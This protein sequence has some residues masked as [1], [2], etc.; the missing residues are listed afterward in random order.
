MSTRVTISQLMALASTRRST[1]KNDLLLGLRRTA[2]L[3]VREVSTHAGVSPATVNR[4]E[5]GH[6][7]D[8]YTALKLAR[9]YE[10]AVEEL[11]FGWLLEAQR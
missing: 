7:V 6:S 8:V 3:T 10:M 2:C 1:P 5:H 9:F 4:A 11:L